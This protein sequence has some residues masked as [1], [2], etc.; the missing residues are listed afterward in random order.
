MKTWPKEETLT[1]FPPALYSASLQSL[2]M[3]ISCTILMAISY[4]ILVDISS[5][6]LM[7]ISCT[8]LVRYLLHNIGGNL[9][10]NIGRYL[11]HIFAM[12]IHRGEKRCVLIRKWKW[13]QFLSRK[14]KWNLR[15]ML[16][17]CT[18]TRRRKKKFII[19]LPYEIRRTWPTV[20]IGKQTCFCMMLKVKVTPKAVCAANESV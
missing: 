14:W 2:L 4:K 17:H 19:I 16:A 8:I 20:R 9:P 3:A 12:Q 13:V 10:Q 6:I 15:N 7:A 11:P 18:N 5:T 1:T